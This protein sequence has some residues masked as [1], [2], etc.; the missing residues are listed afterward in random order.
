MLTIAFCSQ[1]ESM[2]NHILQEITK[3]FSRRGIDIQTLSAKNSEDLLQYADHGIYP[4][5]IIFSDSI[6]S[7]KFINTFLFLKEQKHSIIFILTKDSESFNDSMGDDYT[8]L[9]Q[10][11]YHV[12][13]ASYQ[14][15]WNSVC[16]AYDYI[17]SDKN[18]FSYYHRPSYHST[19]LN[20]ILY[21]ASEGRCVRLVTKY[22]SDS[23]YGRLSE[24]ED[25]LRVK[26]CR[27]IRVHQSYLVNEKY[28]TSFNRKFILLTSGE[29]LPI[30]KSEYYHA[31]QKKSILS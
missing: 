29:L 11:I 10:P 7:K 31:L 8:F 6:V 14:E 28:I 20:H 21:F 22:G 27:F 15:L 19:P 13:S 26:N 16:K 2:I 18:T 12:S 4:D 3:D 25:N 5:I 1:Q 24:L 30:S 9:L 17:S 23:F